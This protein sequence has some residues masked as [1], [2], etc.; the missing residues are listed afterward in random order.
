METK[1]EVF[2]DF[3]PIY[4]D[5]IMADTPF[6]KFLAKQEE[7][8]VGT[9]VKAIKLYFGQFGF[10]ITKHFL[11]EKQLDTHKTTFEHFWTMKFI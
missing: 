11:P 4:G 3:E 2:T 1:R 10:D 7:K 9:L 5:D 8:E 6:Y